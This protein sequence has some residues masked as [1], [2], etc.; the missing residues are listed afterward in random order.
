MS[1]QLDQLRRVLSDEDQPMRVV[2]HQAEPA[3]RYNLG[4]TLEYPHVCVVCRRYG[5]EQ[6]IQQRGWRK[7]W[8]H[9]R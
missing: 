9:V 4:T 3:T 5:V 7:R 6:P 1:E 2:E 8:A